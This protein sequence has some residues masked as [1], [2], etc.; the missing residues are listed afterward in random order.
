[1]F[2]V[3]RPDEY[4]QLALDNNFEILHREDHDMRDW[5][6]ESVDNLVECLKMHT[7]G[8]FDSTHFDVDAMEKHF[9]GRQ[10]ILNYP[11]CIIV[12]KT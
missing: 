10:I 8:L 6:Y 9:D 7:R 11:F 1:M 3:P 12:C 2:Q 4:A 5:H